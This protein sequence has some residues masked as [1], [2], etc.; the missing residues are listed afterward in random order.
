[1][2]EL[3]LWKETLSK[4]ICASKLTW[5]VKSRVGIWKTLASVPLLSFL[6]ERRERGESEAR[7]ICM[8]GSHWA[9]PQM[10]PA[11]GQCCHFLFQWEVFG[12]ERCLTH[13][14]AGWS[15]SGIYQTISERDCLGLSPEKCIQD[16]P[17]EQGSTGFWPEA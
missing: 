10:L 13:S 17:S 1:M 15:Q 7:G 5:L 8:V 12:R 14:N 3:G 11:C 16:R 2:R 6:F 9:H 4:G